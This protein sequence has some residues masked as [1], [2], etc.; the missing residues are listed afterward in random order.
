VQNEEIFINSE[1]EFLTGIFIICVI[2]L[3]IYYVSMFLFNI[4]L[5]EED[6]KYLELYKPSDEP[7]KNHN[8]AKHT[9]ILV[10]VNIVSKLALFFNSAILIACLLKEHI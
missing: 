9:V 6:S 2:S 7:P 4:T 3:V 8:L 5:S 10:C 1:Q